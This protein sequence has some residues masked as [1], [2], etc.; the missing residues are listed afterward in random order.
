MP[1]I[2][3]LPQESNYAMQTSKAATTRRALF[4]EAEESIDSD[5][6]DDRLSWQEVSAKSMKTT[7]P[8][9]TK[10]PTAT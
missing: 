7:R 4:S 2:P 5:D 10:L 1:Q 3:T 6:N 9:T 8:R